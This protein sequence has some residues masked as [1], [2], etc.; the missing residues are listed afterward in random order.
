MSFLI[1]THRPA[2]PQGMIWIPAGTFVMGGQDDAPDNKP[3]HSATLDGFWMDKTEVTNQQ[4]EVF[5]SATGYK[6]VA[7][8]KPDAKDFPGVPEDKLVPGAA[9]FTPPLGPVSLDEHLIWWRYVPGADWRHPGGPE[10]NLKGRETHPV[11]NTCWDDAAAYA[12]WAGKSLPTEAQWEY[13]ARGGLDRQRYVWG[14]E[15]TPNGKWQANIWQGR[16]PNE[17]TEL[18]GFRGTSPVASFPPNGYGLYDMAGNVWEWCADWY[19]PDYY[20]N[21]PLENPQGPRESF[22]PS[23][24][25]MPKRVQRGGSILCSDMYCIRYLPGA[26]GKGAPDTG[27][28]HL[29]FRCVKQPAP[30]K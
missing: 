13:A 12:K 23:E 22:D 19:R 6:T 8:R 26:R 27:L 18:D 28:S 1:G 29:G 16:F 20:E 21:S 25:G 15:L 9:V 3:L 4:F 14:A 17:N 7:E 24:P 10:T 11:V 2:A 30:S 5:V